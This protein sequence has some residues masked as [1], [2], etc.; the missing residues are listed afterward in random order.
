MC[1]SRIKRGNGRSKIPPEEGKNVARGAV[2]SDCVDC[3]GGKIIQR[4]FKTEKGA[5]WKERSGRRRGVLARRRKWGLVY[6][7][8]LLAIAGE[9]RWWITI[10]VDGACYTR[11]ILLGSLLSLRWISTAGFNARNLQSFARFSD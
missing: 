10:C 8:I 2:G 3:Y 4:L 9:G 11:E 1:Y 7:N 5:Q 6:S